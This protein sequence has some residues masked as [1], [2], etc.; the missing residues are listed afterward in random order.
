MANVL[1]S[2]EK[3]EQLLKSECKLDMLEAGGV[4]NWSWYGESLKP[5]YGKSQSEEYEII[6]KVVS[7]MEEA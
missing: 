7:G 6:E 2:K 5:E 4:D 3:Y 1:V